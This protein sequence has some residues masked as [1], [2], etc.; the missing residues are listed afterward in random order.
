MSTSYLPRLQLE[1]L[2]VIP[3]ILLVTGT[4]GNVLNCCIFVRR[5]LRSNSCSQYFLASSIANL[6]SI[7][8]GGLTRL[9]SSFGIL[10]PASYLP[11]FCKIRTFVT[12]IG[13]SGSTW[14]LVGASADR[15]ASSSSSATVRSFSRVKIARRMLLLI[16]SMVIAVYFQM[17]FCFDGSLQAANCFPSSSFC[18]KFN[19]FNLL[20][21]F[22]LCPPLSMLILGWLTIRHVRSSEVLRQQT[23]Q[24]K[25]RQLTRMLLIQVICVTIF[26][27]PISVQK[28][29]SEI[30]V[31]QAKSAEHLLIENFFATFVVLLALINTSTSF[32]L[33][34][35]TG[36]V[37]RRELK[38]LVVPRRLNGE[39]QP[40]LIA[41]NTQIAWRKT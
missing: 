23:Q 39:V 7:Y 3:S 35:L 5:S 8:F 1:L 22:S 4:V 36:K 16:S 6:L 27:L 41:T 15:F 9:L 17:L 24:G 12:Y 14:F 32:Y 2:R 37:F 31:N 29:Y 20:L 18:S 30:T 21:T 34:T 38:S 28:L 33:F 10:P 40:S 11:L 26:C 25:D 13:L 19:N